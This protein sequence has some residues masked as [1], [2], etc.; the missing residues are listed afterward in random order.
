MTAAAVS[1]ERVAQSLQVLSVLE[2]ILAVTLTLLGLVI[3]AILI[4][5]WTRRKQNGE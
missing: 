2:V 5:R 4:A 3:L 1:S